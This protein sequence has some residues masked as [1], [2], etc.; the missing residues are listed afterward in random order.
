[1]KRIK[2]KGILKLIID[3]KIERGIKLKVY[4]GKIVN[5]K[6]RKLKKEIN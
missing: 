1:M 6:F 2:R 4:R 3:L 5:L